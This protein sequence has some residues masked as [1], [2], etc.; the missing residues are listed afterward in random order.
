MKFDQY[1][2]ASP[3]DRITIDDSFLINLI[4]RVTKIKYTD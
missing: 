2:V 4:D 1:V 3:F